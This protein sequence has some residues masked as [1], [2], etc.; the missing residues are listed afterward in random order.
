MTVNATTTR[1][2]E[3][4]MIDTL[5]RLVKLAPVF[6]SEQSDAEAAGDPEND[7]DDDDEEVF[8][9]DGLTV[10]HLRGQHDQQ[11]HAGG[12]AARR[13][14]VA[15]ISAED[16]LSALSDIYDFQITANGE[17]YTVRAEI[18]EFASLTNP[19]TTDI[20]IAGTIDA[21]NGDPVGDFQRTMYSNGIVKNEYLTIE[22]EFQN[23]GIGTEFAERTEQGL[24]DELG[25]FTF[26]LNAVDVGRYSWA[27]AGYGTYTDSTIEEWQAYARFEVRN[28][29]LGSDNAKYREF[30]AVM[31]QWDD[32]RNEIE[33]VYGADLLAIS[34]RFKQVFLSSSSWDG[35]KFLD[36]TRSASLSILRDDPG[37]R[38]PITQALRYNPDQPR[39]PAGSSDG[40]RWGGGGGPG[41]FEQNPA[42]R[43]DGTPFPYD[44][45]ESL[46]DQY[47]GN[48]SNAGKFKQD[49]AATVV[50][51]MG[52]ETR[53]EIADELNAQT[54][55]EMDSLQRIMIAQDIENDIADFGL[56]GEVVGRL[57]LGVAMQ[58]STAAKAWRVDYP[59]SE[60]TERVQVAVEAFTAGGDPAAMSAI[61]EEATGVTVAHGAVDWRNSQWQQSAVT[62]GMVAF[63]LA[64]AEQKNLSAA[65]AALNGY[66]PGGAM[67]KAKGIRNLMPTTIN[68]IIEADQ[69][70][71]EDTILNGVR[72]DNRSTIT[73]YRGVKDSGHSATNM[74]G[75]TVTQGNPL[76]SWTTDIGI[77]RQFGG[78][79]SSGGGWMM[80]AEVPINQIV[81]MASTTGWGSL[82]ER[83]VILL[84]NPIDIEELTPVNREA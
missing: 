72:R 80:R 14:F 26:E 13:P 36:P 6:M 32:N 10:F 21:P 15:E 17:K 57:P 54:L 39:V 11:T 68:H 63:H 43:E 38:S 31:A 71:I 35:V 73:V 34:P 50:L 8:T 3:Q 81:G 82:R 69:F 5:G 55:A 44:D 22:P 65:T 76:S 51:Y 20:S 83:E 2:D 25:V 48:E 45:V 62:P 19:G 59:K 66:Y 74:T 1:E 52:E 46:S 47:A 56:R 18:E 12:G 49:G 84:G 33:P 29:V 16:R 64:I 79:H 61:V 41:G 24:A 27:A 28:G 70:A 23:Q 42:T 7:E 9:V 78:E 77:A 75:A 30:E 4:A 67:D 58:L 40:G 60:V 37:S 53:Q